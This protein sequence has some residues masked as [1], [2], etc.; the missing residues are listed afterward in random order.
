MIT[1]NVNV[2]SD[3]IDNYKGF[4]G[5]RDRWRDGTWDL[6]GDLGGS[7]NDVDGTKW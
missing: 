5:D 6:N 1:N 3:D 2:G 4:G 7:N